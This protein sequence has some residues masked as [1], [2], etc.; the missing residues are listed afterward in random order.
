MLCAGVGTNSV[1]P[2]LRDNS[3]SKLRCRGCTLGKAERFNRTLVAEFLYARVFRSESDRR[4][5][6][7]RWMH[8]YNRHRHHTAIGGPPASRARPHANRHACLNS[9][10]SV[11]GDGSKRCASLWPFRSWRWL[12]G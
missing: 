4:I 11:G 12:S 6:L 5:R 3:P 2:R 10:G 8:D 1:K 9:V 7:A